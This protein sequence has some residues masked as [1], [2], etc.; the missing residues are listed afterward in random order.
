MRPTQ[1]SFPKFKFYLVN[2]GVPSYYQLSHTRSSGYAIQSAAFHQEYGHK[3]M[4]SLVLKLYVR[5]IKAKA[6]FWPLDYNSFLSMIQH[7]LSNPALLIPR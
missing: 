4:K 2:N 3:Q 5:S 7:L 6:S 1:L